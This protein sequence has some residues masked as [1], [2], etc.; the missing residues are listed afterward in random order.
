MKMSAIEGIVPAAATALTP[1][2][3]NFFIIL[4]KYLTIYPDIAVYF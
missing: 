4:K 1:G 3:S 2:F